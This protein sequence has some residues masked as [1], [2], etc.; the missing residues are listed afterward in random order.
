MFAPTKQELA[1]IYSLNDELQ[2]RDCHLV[3]LFIC[4]HDVDGAHLHALL[5]ADTA[6][7]DKQRRDINLQVAEL[8][9]ELAEHG[10]TKAF[11]R[12]TQ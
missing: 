2:S 4:S 8:A 3:E 10:T 1:L 11:V 7:D 6:L 12:E 5:S 9:H